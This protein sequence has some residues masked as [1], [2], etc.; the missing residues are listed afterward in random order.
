MEFRFG[1]RTDCIDVKLEELSGDTV[2]DIEYIKFSKSAANNIENILRNYVR[3]YN[4]DLKIDDIGL[5]KENFEKLGDNRYKASFTTLVNIGENT[6][7]AV[8]VTLGNVDLRYNNRNVECNK[9]NYVK[10]SLANMTAYPFGDYTF[11]ELKG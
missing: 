7:V 3:S 10:I 5:T 4:Q 9:E 6:V 1:E 11:E 8:K 2:V